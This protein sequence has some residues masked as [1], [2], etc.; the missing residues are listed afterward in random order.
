MNWDSEPLPDVTFHVGRLLGR[1]SF[2]KVYLCGSSNSFAVKF[3]H[4]ENARALAGLNSKAIKNEGLFQKFCSNHR[5]ILS[6]GYTGEDERWIWFVLDVAGGGDL[7]NFIEADVGVHMDVAHMFFKQLVGAVEYI[8]SKGIAHRDIKPENI[9]LDINGNLLLSDFGLATIFRRHGRTKKSSTV[10]GSAPY[11][12]PEIIAQNGSYELEPVDIWSCGIILFALLTG[13]TPWGFP[14]DRDVCYRQYITRAKHPEFL[15]KAYPW[16]N[17]DKEPLSLI[18]RMLEEDPRKRIKISGIRAHPWFMRKN[19]LLDVDGSC[20]SPIKVAEKLLGTLHIDLPGRK[21]QRPFGRNNLFRPLAVDKSNIMSC[22]QPTELKARQSSMHAQSQPNFES[23][24]SGEGAFRIDD[25]AVLQFSQKAKVTNEL[26]TITQKARKFDDLLPR[27]TLNRFFVHVSMEM[28][29]SYLQG[30]L[31]QKGIR[32]IM[33]NSE[34][35][36][37][38]VFDI[39]LKD[40]RK[41]PLSGKV[42]CSRPQDRSDAFWKYDELIIVKFDRIKGDP[43]EWR[44][45]FKEAARACVDIICTG[46][47]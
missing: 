41:C 3:V 30:F 21:T 1:G 47:D 5:N 8:H 10:C 37:H 6:C 20:P 15:Q 26:V 7:F 35:Q 13:C 4:K 9:L 16:K 32:Q 46:D 45:V 2:A 34:E 33:E 31:L 38:F 43:L 11:V 19:P 40:R 28:L 36:E 39:S 17:I 22:S 24:N 29:K 25:L 23:D 12:A 18:V 44:H 27:D 14:G 42:T